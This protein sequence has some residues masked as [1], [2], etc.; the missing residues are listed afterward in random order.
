MNKFELFSLIYYVLEA[1]Y[2]LDIEDT[3]INSVVSDM[4]PFIFDDIGLEDP[5][6]YDEYK[7]FNEGKGITVER[8]FDIAKEYLKTTDY[9][10]VTPALVG[11]T[12]EWWIDG[13]RSIFHSHIK[14][15]TLNC[16]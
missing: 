13:A 16:I 12:E 14:G 5:A 4:N 6:V 7:D 10:D 11:T 9:A 3:F 2:G 15:K 1:Y 8:S